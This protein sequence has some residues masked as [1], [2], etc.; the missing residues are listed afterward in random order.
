MKSP[1]HPHEKP[2]HPHWP[3]AC[4]LFVYVLLLGLYSVHE[5]STW[6]HIKTGAKILADGVIPRIDSYSYTV[7]GRPWTTDSWLSD[8]LFHHLHRSTGAWGLILLKSIVAALAF[9]LLLPLNASSPLLAAGVLGA[10]ALASWPGLTETPVFFDLLMLSL[11]IR[12]LRPRR[13]F[14]W[15]MVLQVALIEL[16]WAN[17]HGTTAVLG[18]WVAGLKA[19]KAS[20]RADAEE[21]LHHGAILVA[22]L[23]GCLLNPHGFSVVPHMF[24]G[25]A[26]GWQPLSP[27]FNVYSFFAVGGFWACWV[28]LQQEF[29][30]STTAASLLTASI[31][32][33]ELRPLAILAACP[34]TALAL[35]HHFKPVDDTPAR[36]ARWALGMACLFAVYHSIVYVPLASARGY[37]AVSLAGARSFLKANGVSGRMFNEVETGSGLLEADRLVFVDDRAGL[38]GAA[39]MKDA[40]RW[41]GRWKQLV[42]IYDFD[43]A[44]LLNRRALSYARVID[45]DPAWVLAYADDEALVYIKRRG[46]S[47]WLV[48]G[49]PRRLILP[50]RLWPDALDALLADPKTRVRALEELDRWIV[51]APD[52]AQALLWKAYALAVLNL[53]QKAQHLLS[54]ARGRGAFARDPELMAC[55]AFVL[56]RSGGDAEAS[57][58][59]HRAAFFLRRR[60]ERQAEALVLARL[61]ALYARQNDPKA[62]AILTR[63]RML[64]VPAAEE[65]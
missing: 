51:Q 7:T 39:F 44:V 49:A 13:K 60:G 61:G 12:T 55:A 35:G 56:E 16:L 27:W 37:G 52:S 43:Y 50:G 34:V 42:E 28:C 31:V 29:F 65:P 40:A 63:S 1:A 57:R 54:L 58:L 6:L 15:S 11:L 14:A 4:L 45:E 22:A 24:S 33:P 53:P 46:A 25:S 17:L 10:G 59:Y 5:P 41:P 23:A 47:G 9:V 26:A 3:L 19:F 20:L 18:V 64:A 32:V 2:H 38:Y 21:R 48:A 30:L 62:G 8:I 36:V